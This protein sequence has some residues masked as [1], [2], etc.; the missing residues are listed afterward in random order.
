[1]QTTKYNGMTIAEVAKSRN[2]GNR[3]TEEE[4]GCFKLNRCLVKVEDG[5]VV[6]AEVWDIYGNEYRHA[7]ADFYRRHG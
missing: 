5:I 2:W 7:Q 1:M 3:P 6:D 4:P